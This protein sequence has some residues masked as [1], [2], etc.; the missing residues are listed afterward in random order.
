MFHQEALMLVAEAYPFHKHNVYMTS[1]EESSDPISQF[2]AFKVNLN[3]S[4]LPPSLCLPT[5]NPNVPSPS[6][7]QSD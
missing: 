4:F 7:G 2:A 5:L 3:L 1:L 6:G